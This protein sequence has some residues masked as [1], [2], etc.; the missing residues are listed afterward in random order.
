MQP[1]S[2]G[3]IPPDTHTFQP[4]LPHSRGRID[5][6]IHT[7][8]PLSLH[9][10]EEHNNST[11][12]TF[13]PRSHSRGSRHFP[14][15]SYTFS[16]SCPRS[17]ADMTS[18]SCARSG[19][20]LIRLPRRSLSRFLQAR[21]SKSGLCRV[22]HHLT[23]GRTAL[24]GMSLIRFNPLSF[25]LYF[26]TQSRTGCMQSLCCSWLFTVVMEFMYGISW[27]IFHSSCLAVISSGP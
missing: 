3:R 5:T 25:V 14:F 7:L 13:Q 22:C 16:L 12:N 27:H 18:V 17:W 10:R 6:I 23:G 8:P 1:H 19:G 9:P 11:L 15:I 20:S 2:R 26:D 24:V 4:M 21:C